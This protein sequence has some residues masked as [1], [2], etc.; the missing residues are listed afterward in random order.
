MLWY[1]VVLSR[2]KIFICPWGCWSPNGPMAQLGRCLQSL[3]W[4]SLLIYTFHLRGLFTFV[5]NQHAPGMQSWNDRGFSPCSNFNQQRE[6]LGVASHELAAQECQWQKGSEQLIA[7]WRSLPL[8][9]TSLAPLSCQTG[10]L[11]RVTQWPGALELS[12]ACGT[13]PKEL[14][15]VTRQLPWR[16]HLCAPCQDQWDFRQR[17]HCLGNLLMPNAFIIRLSVSDKHLE[18]LVGSHGDGSFWQ[19]L[20]RAEKAPGNCCTLKRGDT[21]SARPRLCWGPLYSNPTVTEPFFP[22]A[23]WQQESQQ[24]C[25]MS[26]VPRGGN[27]LSPPHPFPAQKHCKKRTFGARKGQARAV[28]VSD[29]HLFI[30]IILSAS[31]LTDNYTQ[32]PADTADWLGYRQWCSVSYGV[33]KGRKM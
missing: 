13:C 6:L 15:R 24:P 22:L 25:G 20:T 27:T 1:V 2:V 33:N 14:I 8:V 7:C 29:L 30:T 23:A 18:E 32:Q 10:W 19:C 31:G 5:L 4:P 28:H 21:S 17:G 16:S 26:P 12:F 9:C 11:G 3:G